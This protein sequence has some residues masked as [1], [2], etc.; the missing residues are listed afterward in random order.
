M[1]AIS[2]ASAQEAFDQAAVQKIKDEGMTRSKVMQTAFMMTDVAGPRLTGSP[3]LRKAQEWAAAQ[4]KAL[5]LQNVKL[6]S[7][8]VPFGPGWQ[9]DKSYIALTAPYYD[10]LIAYPKAWSG[11]TNGLVKGEVMLFKADSAADLAKYKGKLAGKILIFDSPLSQ[12]KGRADAFT[13]MDG[14][15]Y[16][17]AQLATM[18]AAAPPAAGGGRA[19]A[20]A[21]APGAAG[22]PGGARR[23]VGAGGAA[24]FATEL[25]AFLLAEKPAAL[26]RIGAGNYG[27][28]FTTGGRA[29]VA[30]APAPL[31][32]L[33]MSSEDYL[34]LLRIVK[35][36]IKAEVETDIKTSFYTKDLN[37][38]N[39][40]GEI[41]GTDPKLK[42]E[43]VMVGAH[44]DSWHAGTG[45]TDNAAGCAVMME[46]MRI[47]KATGLK[48]KRTIRIALWSGEEQGLNGSKYYVTNH[49]ADRATMELKPEHEKLDAYY[50]LDNG[51]GK[52]RGIYLQGNVAAG[53]IFQSWLAPF[54]DLGAS[55][56]TAGNT[57]G[58]DHQSYDAVGLPGFQFIQDGMDYNTRTHHSNEDTFDRLNEDDLKQ[59]ATIIATFVYN[60]S[61]RTEK[62]P[63]KPLP[64]AAP[65]RTPGAAGAPGAAPAG[66]PV[67]N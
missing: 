29:P 58:T 24:G 49:F 37:E 8:G 36:G 40:V 19:G 51:T 23:Q 1:G 41:P 46:V 65:A 5:G 62:I 60:T 38:Y 61:E 13:A 12:A 16:T 25:A 14:S 45:A 67:R 10:A 28:L 57:G 6:E 35:A 52:V 21:G 15:R 7:W 47:I 59:A 33:D 48:P 32:E 11:S 63:R 26:L 42:N 17:D 66:A 64:A 31:A 44:F 54:K 2:A 3:G 20:G 22:A 34:R 30:G 43:I 53:P 56:V 50:N 4:M 18:A 27:T 9:I 55:T 39:V